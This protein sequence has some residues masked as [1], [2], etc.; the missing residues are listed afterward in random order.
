[1]IS[2]MEHSNVKARDPASSSQYRYKRQKRIP[3]FPQRLYDMLEQAE[4]RGY[5]HIFSW[6]PG[7][8]SFKIHPTGARDATTEKA[9]VDVL[10]KNNFQQTKVRSFL[11]QLNQY[12]FERTHRGPNK[13]ECKHEFFVRGRRDMLE[14]KSIDDFQR[15]NCDEDEDEDEAEH[16]QERSFHRLLRLSTRD[17]NSLFLDMD[18][19]NYWKPSSA[20]L[21]PNGNRPSQ[22]T[23]WQKYRKTHMIPSS[24]CIN[25]NHCCA[26]DEQ[27]QHII[28]FKNGLSNL[29]Q[30]IQDDQDNC[31]ADAEWNDDDTIPTIDSTDNDFDDF[32]ESEVKKVL[33][34]VASRSLL[35]QQMKFEHSTKFPKHVRSNSFATQV[36]LENMT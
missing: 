18:R 23:S 26:G 2:K 12:G 25:K 7:G 29:A 31:Q 36:S 16:A 20:N 1:M 9:V 17:H 34:E 13:G 15:H 28:E 10:K 11:R 32:V 4:E 33:C 8:K 24:M 27:Q 22:G 5:D 6:M 14:D 21:T 3:V 35:H 30:R 19:T